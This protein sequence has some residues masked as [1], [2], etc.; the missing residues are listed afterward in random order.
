MKEDNSLETGRVNLLIGLLGLL[1][2]LIGLM[3][4]IG[5]TTISGPLPPTRLIKIEENF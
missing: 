1:V 5:Q 4:L 2:L 3:G